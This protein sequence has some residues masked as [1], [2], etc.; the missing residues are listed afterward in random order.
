MFRNVPSSSASDVSVIRQQEGLGQS[1]TPRD[2]SLQSPH[3]LGLVSSASTHPGTGLL[4]LHTPWDRS[5]Q[6]PDCEKYIYQSR[7][8]TSFQGRR[9]TMRQ[10]SALPSVTVT[11]FLLLSSCEHSQS[12]WSGSEHVYQLCQRI[13]TE[14]YNRHN[15]REAGA[16]VLLNYVPSP[17]GRTRIRLNSSPRR[18]LNT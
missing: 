5:P 7:N 1:H 4:G 2:W 9:Q 14:E 8:G 10:R 11:S 3:T 13:T 15:E 17:S 18:F 6:P 12:S 16:R